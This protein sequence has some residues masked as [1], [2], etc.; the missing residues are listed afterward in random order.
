[1]LIHIGVFAMR[2]RKRILVLIPI[3]GLAA[4]VAIRYVQGIPDTDPNTIRVSGNI[5]VVDVAS[6]FKTAGWLESRFVSEGEV[7]TA[8]SP[9][10]ELDKEE[11]I[12]EVAIRNAEVALSEARL[13]ELEAG[14]RVE[15]LAKAAARVEGAQARLAELQAGSRKQEVA[16]AEAAVRSAQ[17]E[18]ERLRKDFERQTELFAE[19]VVPRRELDHATAAFTSSEGALEQATQ[20]LRLVKEGPRQ[21]LIAQARAAL[22]EATAGYELVLAGPRP[23]QVAQAR[24]ELERARQALALAE[25]RLAHS[26]I[27]ARI[28]GIVLAEHVEEGEYVTPGRPVVTIGNLEEVWLRAYINQTDL[29]RVKVGQPVAVYTDSFSGK[30]YPGVVSFVSSESEFTPKSVQTETERVKLV[31]RVKIDIANPD[32]ELKPGMP[33]DAHIRLEGP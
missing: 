5:E 12:Q 2:K 8:G 15:D 32:L 18:R 27:T 33:A 26:R 3:V 17:A 13:A 21:E 23:E 14:S 22:A 9:V 16:A 30:V 31:Y 20:Q 28:S 7:V 29:G 10:A 24:A 19:D 6:S 1:M 25:T 11:L 4:V